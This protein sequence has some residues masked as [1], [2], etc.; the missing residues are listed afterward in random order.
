MT[1]EKMILLCDNLTPVENEVAQFIL[2]NKERIL[3]LSIQQLA[4]EIF[5]S[6]SAIHRLCK[7]L[8][9]R[10]F[11][12][13]KVKLAQEDSTRAS[14][15]S[16]DVNY[17][18]E[19]DDDATNIAKRL[20]KLYETTIQDTFH[21][22]E[23]KQLEVVAQKM[24]EASCI[25][26][27]THAHNLNAAQ[28]FSDKML[29]IGRVVNCPTSFY[30]QRLTALKADDSHVALILSYSGKATYIAPLMK[31]LEKKK[32]AIVLIGK[33]GSNAYPSIIQYPL[34][35]SGKENLRNRISQFSSHI[36]LQYMLDVLFACIYN[37]EREKNMTYLKEAIHFMDDRDVEDK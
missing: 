6:K 16:I 24:K 3:H 5:V 20:M 14:E 7:K 18:F 28:N 33:A 11:N 32:I 9:F 13:L 22:I 21:F 31:I 8:S 2:Q 15:D 23:T 37:K 19:A 1:L 26:V 29:T 10:G 30:E 12:E 35:I 17:P 4:D 34:Y 27:Y 25:D 36:A